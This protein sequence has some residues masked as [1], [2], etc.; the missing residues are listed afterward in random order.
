MNDNLT[1]LNGTFETVWDMLRQGVG[2]K[3]SPANQLVLATSSPENGSSARMV[4]LRGVDQDAETLHFFTHARS[5]KVSDLNKDERGEIL[6]W[7]ARK[8][9]Q[10]RIS[11]RIE[12]TGVDDTIWSAL[13]PGTRMNYA[14]EPMPGTPITTPNDA[15]LATPDRSQMLQLNAHVWQIETLW[16]SNQGLYRAVFKS[17]SSQW[18]AP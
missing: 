2:E 9:L 14:I 10:I 8:Q 12:A 17:G 16:I 13:G 15:R 1:S 5:Q 3:A 4:V 6:I 7:D 11:V 18:I